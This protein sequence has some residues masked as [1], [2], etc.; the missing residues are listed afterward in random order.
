MK[1]LEKVCD[2]LHGIADVTSISSDENKMQSVISSFFDEDVL[3]DT[4]NC[5]KISTNSDSDYHFLIDAHID[6]IGMIVTDITES[7]F[8]KVSNVGGIDVRTLSACDVTI[9]AKDGDYFGVVTSVPPHL[10]EEKNNCVADIKDIMIDVGMDKEKCENAISPGDLVS[11]SYTASNL[12]N[13]CVLLPALDNKAGT[14]VII[15]VYQILKERKVKAVVTYLFSAQEELGMRGAKPSLYN[16]NVNEAIV[17]DVSFAQAPDVGREH[18]KQIGKGPMICVSPSIDREMSNM[19][20]STAKK[21]EI[22]YQIEVCEGLTGTN[23]DVISVSGNGIKTGLISVPLRNMHT[24][25]EVVCLDD[26]ENTAQ[27]IAEYIEN[28]VKENV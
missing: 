23:A 7:G 9:H 2:I 4:L 5:I 18:A 1:Q 10:S 14:T 13:N 3:V 11:F 22:P 16:Q 15:R 17:V 20:I 12:A 26:I 21:Y 6:Q 27:L 25:S 24:Y 28:R 8:I 19:F